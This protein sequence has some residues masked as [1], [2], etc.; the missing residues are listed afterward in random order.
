MNRQAVVV[1]AGPVGALSALLLARRGI[2]VTLIESRTTLATESHAS[3]FHPSTL[4]LLHAE[5]IDLSADPEA[6]RVTSIQ[7]RDNR[8]AI[9]AEIDY[10][11]L[12]GRTLHPFRIHLEQ[13]A[14]LDRLAALI[15]ADHRISFQPGLTATGLDPDTTGVTVSPEDGRDH[16]VR[17]DV[18]IGCDGSHSIVRAAAG[19][20]FRAVEYPTSAIRAHVRQDLAVLMP[21][22]PQTGELAGL[23][24]FRGGGD[25]V[26]ALR[27]ARSTRLI[28]RTTHSES[29]FGRVRAAVTN[30]TPW[31]VDDLAIERIDTY[32]LSRGVA[33]R[34][35]SRFGPVLV[36]GDAAHVTSTAGGLNMNSGIQ[37][38]FALMPALA[39]WLHGRA[40]L[41][42][43]EKIAELRR[44]YVVEEVIPRSERRV[45]GLQ[46]PGHTAFRE[47]LDDISRLA[48]DPD[49]ARQFLIEASLLDTPLQLDT[50]LKPNRSPMKREFT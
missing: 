3:T 14:L 2:S 7:W 16:T 32:R 5:G 10:R 47:H 6:V 26:S 20:G 17:A 36:L 18:V 28:V 30:A 33:D 42:S 19:I 11:L 34:Y 29:D 50:P 1:G 25:G 9:Q 31:S 12:D 45:R 48:A 40:E 46:D 27:M 49:A 43:V 15:T 4:D 37:D 41:D 22:T 35:V 8:G 21:S 23:C 44:N 38:A 13:Q 39:D 24:Y